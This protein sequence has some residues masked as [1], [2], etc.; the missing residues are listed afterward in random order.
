MAGK[1]FKAVL[2]NIGKLAVTAMHRQWVDGLEMAEL[3][4]LHDDLQRFHFDGASTPK[5]L[6]IFEFFEFA[7]HDAIGQNDDESTAKY[8]RHK[9]EN[10]E[11]EAVPET[12]RKLDALYI[13]LCH[14]NRESHGDAEEKKESAERVESERRL[15][16]AKSRRR[17]RRRD[18][19]KVMV[20][21][22]VT[23]CDR[24]E[25]GFGIP[26]NYVHLRPQ[27]RSMRHEL[28]CNRECAL[29]HSQFMGTLRDAISVWTGKLSHS[30]SSMV[31]AR[32]YGPRDGILRNER[33]TMRH[34]FGL[35]L[36]TNLSEFCCFRISAL[37]DFEHIQK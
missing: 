8:R 5:R 2:L 30:S 4:R 31:A 12:V 25:Y 14:Q 11:N 9:V 7:V 10:A 18:T 29:S 33:I 34:V 17:L 1:L 32:E 3:K 21:K 13:L 35:L 22:Y 26:F 37:S 19:A 20:W 16:K 23:E 28:V 24:G 36:Y 27:C 6:S 15:N